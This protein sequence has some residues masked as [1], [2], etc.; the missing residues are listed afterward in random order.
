MLPLTLET[1]TRARQGGLVLCPAP[2]QVLRTP[3]VQSQPAGHTRT[4]KSDPRLPQACRG[5]GVK[6]WKRPR[7]KPQGRARGGSP[8]AQ[9][10]GPPALVLPDF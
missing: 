8:A 6:G 3:R 4:L 5:R 9:R 2:Q 10:E 7:E 1:G